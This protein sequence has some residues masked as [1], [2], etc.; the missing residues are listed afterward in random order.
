[1]NGV[2]KVA[3]N[4]A[5]HQAD[6]GHGVYI[7]GITPTPSTNL[8]P[9]PYE[10]RLFQAKKNKLRIDKSIKQ[11][12]D[13]LTPGHTY[14]HIHGSFIPEFY[15][16][17]KYLVSKKIPY[18]YCPHGSLSPG[19]LQRQKWKKKLYFKWIESYILRKAQAI[20]FLG[21][22]QYNAIDSLLE[23]PHKKLIPNGQNLNELIFSQSETPSGQ[24]PIF[25]F[26]GRL[27][28]DHKG[29]DFLLD[30][31]ARYKE[32]GGM[33]T[34]WL[35]GDGQDRKKLEAQATILEIEKSTIFWGAKYGDEKLNLLTQS[36]AFV[37]L[38]RYEGLPTGVLE[39]A[40]LG[41]PCILTSATN[42]GFQFAE[43]G[44][45]IHVQNTQPDTVCKAFKEIEH[46]HKT[47]LLARM[48]HKAKKLIEQVYNWDTITDSVIDMYSSR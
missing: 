47:G 20:H 21:E 32:E 17:A 34:L 10:I 33:G 44:A 31:F 22:T 30:G 25:S 29:L 38:S 11:A 7:W 16:V 41:L 43:A 15:W 26:C 12:I 14:V 24:H 8:A 3:H 23:V 28:Q 27:D 36:D 4:L 37:H 19:A 6:R 5:L 9:R 42:L 13:R 45:G 46:L 40:G 39:A 18:V 2:N 1:M 48:G 35:I